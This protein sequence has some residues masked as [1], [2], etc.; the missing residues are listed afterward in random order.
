[1]TY[2]LHKVAVFCGS[3][4]GGNSAYA[5]A[6]RELGESLAKRK[7]SLIFGGGSVGLMGELSFAALKARGRVLGFTP[8]FLLEQEKPS[9]KIDLQLVNTMAERKEM[10]IRTADAFIVLPGG[11]GTFEEVFETFSRLQL[12][13][14]N[15]AIGFLNVAG[16]FDPFLKMFDALVQEG[17]VRQDNQKLFCVGNTV[18]E[19]LNKLARFV[20]FT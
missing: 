6:A 4:V 18:G 12:R 5:A 7:V 20:P 1:M 2:Q 13:Q 15:K 9:Y 17:F 8:R 10:M 14:I 11:I 3:T 16:F 19:L